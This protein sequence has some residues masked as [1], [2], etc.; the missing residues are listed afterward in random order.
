MSKPL[1]LFAPAV[2]DAPKGVPMGTS[3]EDTSQIILQVVSP[4]KKKRASLRKS[5]ISGGSK[6][7]EIWNEGLLESSLDVSDLHGDF[8]GDGNLS[9]LQANI[10]IYLTMTSRILRVI[11]ICPE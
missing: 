11:G 1:I 5:E 8:Y 6:F 7:V 4:S 9:P 3:L 10:M 2:E